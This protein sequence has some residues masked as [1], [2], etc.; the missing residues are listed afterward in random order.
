VTKV[1]NR[2]DV[3][4]EDRDV[5]AIQHA[6]GAHD[7]ALHRAI[8]PLQLERVAGLQAGE[9][10]EDRVAMAAQHA[11]AAAAGQRCAVDVTGAE[12]E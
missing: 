8:R 5:G 1:S 4:V 6:G 12:G 3:A 9:E 10:T 11:V 2:L 7:E